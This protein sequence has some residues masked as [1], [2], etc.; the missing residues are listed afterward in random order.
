MLGPGQPG[1]ESTPRRTA[2]EQ[3]RGTTSIGGSGGVAV[4]E[5]LAGQP[6]V[7]TLDLVNRSLDARKAGCEGFRHTFTLTLTWAPYVCEQPQL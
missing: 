5:E 1:C 6:Q 2:T 7:G 3:T 4:R